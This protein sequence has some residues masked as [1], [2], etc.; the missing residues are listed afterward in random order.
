MN[1]ELHACKTVLEVH[2]KGIREDTVVRIAIILPFV[3]HID[4]V[5]DIEDMLRIKELLY[6][7]A[8]SNVLKAR[9]EFHT[10]TE[11]LRLR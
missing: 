11:Y 3:D 10:F 4:I 9:V 2:H 5:G 6:R 8:D 7:T 1:T